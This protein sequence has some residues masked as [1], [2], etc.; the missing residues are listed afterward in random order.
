MHRGRARVC[1]EARSY[2]LVLSRTSSA[3]A[4]AC[5]RVL[6]PVRLR[7]PAGRAWIDMYVLNCP[8]SVASPAAWLYV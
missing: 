8:R 1:E 5:V 6:P 7:P 2:P 3:C 4:R